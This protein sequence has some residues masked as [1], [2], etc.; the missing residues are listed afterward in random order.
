MLFGSSGIEHIKAYIL[1]ESQ[2]PKAWVLVGCSSGVN[3]KYETRRRVCVT[4]A[5]RRVLHVVDQIPTQHRRDVASLAKHSR[6]ITFRVHS[7]CL[8]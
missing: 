1:R 7:M 8:L 5:S 4:W 3:A 6:Y 2:R